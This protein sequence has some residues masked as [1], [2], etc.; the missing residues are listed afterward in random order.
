M[1]SSAPRARRG[2]ATKGDREVLDADAGLSVAANTVATSGRVNPTA[3]PPKRLLPRN[4]IQHISKPNRRLQELLGSGLRVISTASMPGHLPAADELDD[5]KRRFNMRE[6]RC[7]P[8]IRGSAKTPRWQSS[9]D[10]PRE[11]FHQRIML[12]H[13]RL[14]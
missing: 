12:Q 7:L 8:T 14:H 11:Y 4:R 5:L 9:S 13:P 3:N 2:H 6:L 10:D 1:T